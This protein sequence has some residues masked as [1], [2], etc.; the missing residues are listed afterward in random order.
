MTL[1][2]EHGWAQLADGLHIQRHFLEVAP[3]KRDTRR[4]AYAASAQDRP[5]LPPFDTLPSIISGALLDHLLDPR[6]PEPIADA[7]R[8]LDASVVNARF[9]QTPVVAVSA[10]QLVPGAPYLV[11]ARTLPAAGN[12]VP[13]TVAEAAAAALDVADLTFIV[14]LNVGV[15]LVVDRAWTDDA[16]TAASPASDT[17]V[18][19]S[20]ATPYQIAEDVVAQAAARWCTWFVLARPDPTL[21]PP[22]SWRSPWSAEPR[23]TLAFATEILAKSV[24][25]RLRTR[26]ASSAPDLLTARE[27]GAI[28]ADID[29]LRDELREADEFVAG[30]ERI[31]E[32]PG[33]PPVADNN[34][35]VDDLLC[36]FHPW[37]RQFHKYW[38]GAGAG[39]AE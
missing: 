19:P 13:P 1:P 4:A 39:Q 8:R 24:R 30:T 36:T 26:V 12:A 32:V 37:P 15:L 34:M 38:H 21:P 11:D 35:D 9:A 20:S 22:R 6:Q 25:L 27:R 33:Q 18:V 31:F 17:V 5:P 23:E 29:R 2:I 7:V 14:Q 10:A 3:L 28:A 16:I